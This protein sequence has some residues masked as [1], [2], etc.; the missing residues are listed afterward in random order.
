MKATNLSDASESVTYAEAVQRGLG[1][2][3]GL[4]FPDAVPPLGDPSVLLEM[5]QVERATHVLGAWVGDE[6]D[7][8]T[9]RGICTRA[10]PFPAPLVQ[11]D[12]TTWALEL[13][14][15][16]TLAFK[17]FGARFM[18]QCLGAF[19]AA[20]S[21]AAEGRTTILTA[22]SGDT[23]AAVA[24]AFYRVP[25]IDCVVL[26]PKGRISRLQEQL[27]C[28]LGENVTT[29]A[30]E[31]TFDDCQTLVKQA[32]DSDAVRARL[33]LTSANSINLARLLAQ[34]TYYVEAWAQLP[35]AAREASPLISV[36]SGNFGNLTAGLFAKAMGLPLSDFCAATNANDT[37]PRYL[38]EGTWTPRAT[39]PTSSNAM[40]V[41]HPSNW[42][43][44]ETLHARQG[45]PL[46]SLRAGAV[47]DDAS[48]DALRRL[49]AMG[50][51]CEPH[52]AIGYEVLHH[53]RE[54]GRPGVFLCTAHPAKFKE[55][56]DATL[57]LD[58]PLPPALA[59]RESMPNLSTTIE[60]EFDALSAVLDSL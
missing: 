16:P 34:V 44:V 23:G 14:H 53:A 20:R 28:T 55:S 41:S 26:Y 18:A 46:A 58:I 8:H 30:V 19:R 56:V 15:G 29:V 17:D 42:I 6:L 22:T 40:D 7:A 10:F 50:Y 4:F 45:W 36:P 13:F 43:R 33:G 37:V 27:F 57:G 9:L 1:R 51:L 32:F 24:H 39:V 52:G 2:K 49:H 59:E 60:A 38:S 25:G 3:R 47:S 21:S 35:S 31:G 12:E 5:S 54:P 48:A 11:V